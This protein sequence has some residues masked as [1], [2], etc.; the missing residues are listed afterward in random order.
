MRRAWASMTKAPW[1]KPFHLAKQVKPETRRMVAAGGRAP[2][3]VI[4]PDPCGFGYSGVEARAGHPGALVAGCKPF[5]DIPA[6]LLEF[7]DGEMDRPGRG[8]VGREG[9]ARR[10]RHSDH[11]LRTLNG[12]LR[13]SPCASTTT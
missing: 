2:N 11:A 12:C 9:A 1:T 5:P 4:W 3:I 13:P 6:I 8:G 7:P 10:D